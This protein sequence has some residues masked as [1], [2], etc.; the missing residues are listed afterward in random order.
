MKINF[1]FYIYFVLVA[2]IPAVWLANLLQSGLEQ[3]SWSA[4]KQLAVWGVIQAPTTIVIIVFLFFIYESALWRIW[5][6]KFIHRVP[7]IN[8]RYRGEIESS[9][10]GGQK[11]PTVI[12]IR[13][14]LLNVSLS[15]FTERS[16]SYSALANLIKNEHG[17]W[18]LNYIYRN[19]PR[20]MSTD[21]DMRMHEGCAML[22][23]LKDDIQRLEGSYYNDSRERGT[24]GKIVCALENKDRIG[25]F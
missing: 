17:G 19:T 1:K 10:N 25:H 11:Y 7:N 8:G 12:E 20:T 24:Y 6:F 2:L 5:P 14:T 4:I 3:A 22:N 18:T 21:I 23:L 9:V 16:S 15:L 13:Q